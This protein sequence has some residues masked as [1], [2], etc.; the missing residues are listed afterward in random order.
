MASTRRWRTCQRGLINIQ[1]GGWAY[2][3]TMRPKSCTLASQ[4]HDSS[5]AS[6][7][8]SGTRTPPDG[9]QTRQSATY[10]IFTFP[11]LEH[12]PRSAS[13]TADAH[14]YLQLYEVVRARRTTT[15]VMVAQ[16]EQPEQPEQQDQRLKPTPQSAR[17][18]AVIGRLEAH[19]C[20]PRVMI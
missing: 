16:T 3:A 17:K 20:S 6:F 8:S 11:F 2:Y 13:Q 7:F 12:F 1:E 15:L 5:L 9:H 4:A 18:H 19:P 10:V 14:N